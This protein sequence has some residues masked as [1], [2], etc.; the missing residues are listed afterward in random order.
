MPQHS[1]LGKKSNHLVKST[2]YNETRVTFE[3]LVNHPKTE[4]I[5][6]SESQ[7]ALNED[8][9]ES[10]IDEYIHFPHFLKFKNRIVIAIL[11][12][13]WYLVDGQHRLEMAKRCYVN[14]SINDEFLFS[15][16]H[17]ENETTMRQ[18]FNS[19]NKDSL[20]NEFYINLEEQKQHMID[21]WFT[22]MKKNYGR[23][24]NKTE[25]HKSRTYSLPTI[26]DK[27]IEIGFFDQYTTAQECYDMIRN[28]N[29]EFYELNRYENEIKYDNLDGFYADDKLRIRHKFVIPSKQCNFIQWLHDPTNEQPYHQRM[30]LKKPISQGMRMKVWEREFYNLEEAICPISTCNTL[31][32]K[33]GKGGFHAGHIISERNDGLTEI[34]NLRPIC[35]HCNCMM[36]SKN[37]KDFD[38]QSCS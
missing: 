9:V 4:S 35:K 26:R 21:I 37:W 16:Y 38:S 8:K 1:Y 7:R 15:W 3:E 34:S 6:Y 28:K 14:H 23:F 10:M 13:R 17:C 19:L 29:N 27:L 11:N 12:G 33:K 2:D 30:K 18:L 32:K 36:T 5:Q 22:M 31:L 25:K 20:G 24:F